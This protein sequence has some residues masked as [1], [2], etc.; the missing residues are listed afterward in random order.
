MPTPYKSSGINPEQNKRNQET[1]QS[2]LT[3]ASILQKRVFELRTTA[4]KNG[5][6]VDVLPD[7]SLGKCSHGGTGWITE[8]KRTGGLL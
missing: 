3:T 4:F 8:V 7:N 2:Q 6:R 5:I 1:A